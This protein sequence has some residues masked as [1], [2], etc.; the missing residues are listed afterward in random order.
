MAKSKIR[1]LEDRV[2]IQ[3][4]EAL[5]AQAGNLIEA[6]DL[7]DM[8]VDVV[9]VRGAEHRGRSGQRRLAGRLPRH[10]AASRL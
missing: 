3:Q 9:V 1:P 6:F 5:A 10:L 8:G 2:V 4:I 7:E